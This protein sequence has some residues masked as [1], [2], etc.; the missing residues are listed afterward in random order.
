[1][2][3]KIMQKTEL[4]EP[5]KV[6]AGLRT[7]VFGR[8]L[9]CFRELT[10]T[11]DI[12]KELAVRGARE[13]TV[14]VAETQIKGRGRLKR[15]WISP[16][17]GIWLSII[18]RPKTE[19][20]HASKLTL[21][22]AVAVAKTINKLFGLNSEIKWP[23][24]VL[25]NRRKV[26]GILTEAKTKGEALDFVIVGIGMNANYSVNTLPRYL[27]GSS[28]TLKEELKKEIERV[29]LLRKLLEETEFYYDVFQKKRFDTILTEWRNSASFLG[30]YVEVVSNSEK[31]R[32]WATGIDRNGALLVRLKDQTIRKVTSG[33]M[34][35][36]KKE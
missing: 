15:R 24:D 30:S 21:M 22:A 3:R 31:I 2:V 6:K 7:R 28:T 34:K 13:G 1:M 4:I 18:L 26:C 33:D 12:A 10:S 36:I 5:L 16:E 35:L 9:H 20:K 32:G 27:R 19:P 8:P 11:N 29:S 25:I 17:G 14:I 23:N